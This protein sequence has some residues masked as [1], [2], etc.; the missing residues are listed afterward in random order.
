MVSMGA[1]YDTLH[2]PGGFEIPFSRPQAA[3][4]RDLVEK[5]LHACQP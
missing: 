3:L 5:F 4:K 2:F 1:V